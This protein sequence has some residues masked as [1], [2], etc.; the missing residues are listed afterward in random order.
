MDVMSISTRKKERGR[1][2]DGRTNDDDDDD[3]DEMAA[4]LERGKEKRTDEKNNHK[5][6]EMKGVAAGFVWLAFLEI[7][8]LLELVQ[9]TKNEQTTTIKRHLFQGRTDDRCEIPL[10]KSC[11][12]QRRTAKKASR[13]K[14]S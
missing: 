6:R 8:S 10:H 13:Q 9:A 2:A 3:D 1:D 4:E 5:K 11:R 14:K 12:R 7:I